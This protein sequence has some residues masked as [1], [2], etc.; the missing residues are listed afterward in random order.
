MG[1]DLSICEECEEIIVYDVR[2]PKLLA[3]MSNQ[4]HIVRVN[5]GMKM[6]I[7]S[8]P[9]LYFFSV[10]TEMAHGRRLQTFLDTIRTRI[11]YLLL[12]DETGKMIPVGNRCDCSSS[13]YRF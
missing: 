13:A 8:R 5:H 1:E 2:M 3:Y 4:D 11:N 12:P 9:G 6:R 10:R 7:I